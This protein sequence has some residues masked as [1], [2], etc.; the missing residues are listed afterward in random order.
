MSG[1]AAA[2]PDRRSLTASRGSGGEYVWFCDPLPVLGDIRVR[3]RDSAECIH[4]GRAQDCPARS[5][6][7]TPIGRLFSEIAL[8]TAANAARGNE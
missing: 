4:E 8:R 6:R 3:V 2:A 7:A 5:T 1:R